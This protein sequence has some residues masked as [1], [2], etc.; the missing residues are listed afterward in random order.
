M[1]TN[2]KKLIQGIIAASVLV[3]IVAVIAFKFVGVLPLLLVCAFGAGSLV[4]VSIKGRQRRKT[5]IILGFYVAANEILDD[6]ERRRYR[7][8]I[9]EAIKTGEKV[10][11]SMP[12]P[13][14]LSSFAL[15]ALYHSIG[16]Q[17][18]AVQHLALAAEEEV[19]KESPHVAPSRQLRRYVRRL[20]QIERR[21]ERWSKFNAAIRNLERMHRERAAHLLAQN[22]VQLKR[23]VEAYEF[24][25][26]RQLVP[27]PTGGRIS[28]DRPLSSV[29]SP[30][31]ISEVLSDVYQED[32]KTSDLL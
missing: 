13:P 17:N 23:M 8:E 16:D 11:S 29:N 12:D 27:A 7:F 14:P 9:A 28:M 22:Q 24:G 3:A 26:S 4:F 15:G 5:E 10:V 32:L 2:R 21:P 19:L 31:P 18:G 20:R 25:G 6:E 1:N 30:R